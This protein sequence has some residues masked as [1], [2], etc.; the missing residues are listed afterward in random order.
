MCVCVC[1]ICDIIP[2]HTKYHNTSLMWLLEELTSVY[3]PKANCIVTPPVNTC[4]YMYMYDCYHVYVAADPP[5]HPIAIIILTCT[6]T[7]CKQKDQSVY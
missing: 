4:T 3:T 7:K 2:V 5:R 6:E 1:V